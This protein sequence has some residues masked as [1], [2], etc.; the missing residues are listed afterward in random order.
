MSTNTTDRHTPV[1]HATRRRRALWVGPLALVLGLFVVISC[2]PYFT[3]DPGRSVVPLNED[4]V[5]GTVH[6][7]LLVAHVTAGTIAYA[8]VVIQV[9]P[10]I[11][12][13]FPAAHRTVGR[14]YVFG[15]MVP[16]SILALAV[17]PIAVLGPVAHAGT[18]PWALAAFTT[19]ITGWRMARRRRWA[20]HRTWMLASVAVAT[21]VVTGRLISLPL[22]LTVPDLA[23]GTPGG[24][25]LA[26]VNGFWLGWML[27]LAVVLLW[28]RHRRRSA[29]SRDEPAAR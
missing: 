5:W 26:Q 23:M 20:E 18:V 13:R 21:G 19:T 12:R 8:C 16:A 2:V 29:V 10:W 22:M 1:D 25:L 27:N 6:Y 28:V 15:G 4:P 14:I 7:V 11:R 24:I 3:L 9:W 17:D